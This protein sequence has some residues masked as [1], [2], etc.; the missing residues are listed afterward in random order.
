[1]STQR[2]LIL[3]RIKTILEG[4]SSLKNVEINKTGPVDLE[5]VAF[6]CAFIYSDRETKIGD[7]RSVIGKENWEWMINIEVW[8]SDDQVQ[9]T[10]LGE[11]HTAMAADYTIG[12]YAVTS[13]RISATMYVLDPERAINSM[14]LDYQVIYRHKVGVP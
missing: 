11:I 5:T 6:P 1:M 9:E 4:V 2:Q 12:G 7:D 13:D 10:L 8:S 3:D 14:V